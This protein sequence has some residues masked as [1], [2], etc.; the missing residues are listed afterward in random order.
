VA[1]R[2]TWRS[3]GTIGVWLALIILAWTIADVRYRFRITTAPLPLQGITF[4]MI[5][6]VGVLTLLTDLWRAEQWL[7]PQGNILTPAIWQALLGGF[8]FLTFLIWA[9]FAFIKPPIYG[10]R[11][12][13]RYGRA[14][15]QLVLKGNS[16][17]LP[18][19]ADEFI[20]SVKSLIYYATDRGMRTRSARNDEPEMY[21]A[22]VT[23]YADTI[24]LLIADKRFCRALVNSSP[25]T[26]LAVFNEIGE[27]RKYRVQIETFAR[28]V[29][30]EA[31]DNMDSFLFHE[32][33]GYETGLLGYHK[34]LSQAMFS[35]YMMVEAIGTLLDVAPA[36]K[37]DSKQLNAYCRAVLMTVNDY[38]EK[39]LIWNHSNV[40]YRA[41]GNIERAVSDLYQL[42]GV[43]H[44]P[45][46][47]DVHSRLRAV[48]EFIK[49]VVKILDEKGVPNSLRLRI[50]DKQN[51]ENF[52]DRLA[53]MTFEVIFWVS[54]VQSPVSLCWWVQHNS[55]WSQ[56]YSFHL[57]G[58][59]GKVVKFK[60]R[61]L[62][63][64]EVA[65]MKNFPNFK[66]AKI[67]GFCL[68]VMGLSIEKDHCD[69]PEP[70]HRAIL[71][72]TKKNYVWLHAENQNVA[73]ACLVDGITY[74][75][76][77]R[78]LVK[79][80]PADGLR[81]EPRYVYLNLLNCAGTEQ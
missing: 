52:Y 39:K 46:D 66:G 32:S 37:W 23:A 2:A 76:Q 50:R 61:R 5:V 4:I 21:P 8:F 71:S 27:T 45:W 16:D 64:D 10:K 40:L 49:D 17:D 6:A 59:A 56:L 60:I 79:T 1:A 69:G 58:K 44:I 26:A 55:V 80:Y 7:V 43:A 62:L 68:N 18:I 70:L 48:V 14:L 73:A 38:V 9:W 3:V 22:K 12:A 25:A 54:A 15:Y 72:W 81:R 11:N 42:Y 35:N 29:I 63:Y 51:R 34:P 24:L 20:R 75:E 53:S 30:Q 77:N 65:R 13:K 78:R 47:D 31:L 36:K 28:N 33:E 19:I 74:D 57:D 41:M 67:L